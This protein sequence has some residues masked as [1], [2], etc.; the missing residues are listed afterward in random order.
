VAPQAIASSCGLSISPAEEFGGSLEQ[1]L[2]KSKMRARQP[3][4][5]F[6]ALYDG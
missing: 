1:R 5:Q 4:T 6:G 2:N 3:S